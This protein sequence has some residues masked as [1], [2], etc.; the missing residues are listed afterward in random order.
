MQLKSAGYNVYFEE[1]DFSY[2]EE[3]LH[4]NLFS[5]VFILC[6]DKTRKYCLPLLIEE[7][8]SLKGAK[9][10]IMPSGEKNKT[11]ST[12]TGCWNF[13]LTNGADRHSLLICLGGGVVCDLGGFAASTFKRG[14]NFIHVPTTLLAMAD[15]SVGGKTGID[16]KGYKNIIGTITQPMGVFVHEEFLDTLPERH[17][18]NGLSEI[19]KAAL[20][21]DDRLW[22]KF[23]RLK[24]LPSTK[25]I[26]FI[27][28]SVK[29]K[30]A[31]VIKDPEEK[32]IRK[33]LNFGHTAGHAIESYY[34]H[35]KKILLHG[36]AIAMGMCVELCLG[37]I[38]K[39]TNPKT[40]LQVFL[41]FKKY[42]VLKRFS[43]K[44]INAFL[45]F[46]QNDKKNQSGRFSF[47]LVEKPGKAVINIHA[48]TDEVKQAFILY[49][50][51]LK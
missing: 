51:L 18:A 45:R 22:R 1:N 50:N 2:L 26:S 40:A 9:V 23:L 43:V 37:K 42:F 32:N 36:E 39:H 13:L 24:K 38:L 48:S 28:S 21:G 35:K 49:N 27:R 8:G 5:S 6:D 20:I 25:F 29:V 46:M 44:E 41:Y 19:I 34:L 30:N 31:I 33:V 17:L 11:L 14:I 16:Y 10:Y 47:A 4:E 12:L 15:A 3:F 7:N